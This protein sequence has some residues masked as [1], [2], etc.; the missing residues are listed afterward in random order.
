MKN[1]MFYDYKMLED[2]AVWT[3]PLFWLSCIIYID[4]PVKFNY[5]ILSCCRYS[6]LAVPH[7]FCFVLFSRYGL[8][9]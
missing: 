7:A 8:I 5:L 3:Q 1:S 4:P 9:M 6:H 2:L